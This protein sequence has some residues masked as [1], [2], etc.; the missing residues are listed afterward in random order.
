MNPRFPFRFSFLE[1]KIHLQSETLDRPKFGRLT[2]CESKT[3]I[4]N[5]ER[6]FRAKSN[7]HLLIQSFLKGKLYT[8]GHTP[9]R[10]IQ[11]LWYWTEQNDF[12]MCPATAKLVGLLND[13]VDLTQDRKHSRK[14]ALEQ[15]KS[16][17]T[18]FFTSK[19][20]QDR[21]SGTKTKHR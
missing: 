21:I 16:I 14:V 13:L 17:I 18:L 12:S 19:A 9:S 7:N 8:L 20:D 1:S 6:R 15:W 4:G 10:N 2:T 5:W 3:F 11:Y